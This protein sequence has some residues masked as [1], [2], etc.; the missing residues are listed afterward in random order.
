M[1]KLPLTICFRINFP[2]KKRGLQLTENTGLKE[3]SASRR[4]TDLTWQPWCCYRET[5]SCIIQLPPFIFLF[6]SPLSSFS[7]KG[8]NSTSPHHPPS[9]PRLPRSVG[10]TFHLSLV[11]LFHVTLLCTLS[12]RIALSFSFFFAF[13]A[14][15]C[16]HL[17]RG[18]EKQMN[19]ERRGKT[20]K[21][22]FLKLVNNL[23]NNQS[24]TLY[25]C[26]IQGQL[27]SYHENLTSKMPRN[28]HEKSKLL[29]IPHCWNFFHQMSHLTSDIFSQRCRKAEPRTQ[30][31]SSGIFLGLF[32]TLYWKCDEFSLC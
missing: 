8:P 32:A 23:I 20:Q 5:D 6:P 19:T 15:L 24:K 13:E 11:A 7:N 4:K 25:H 18:R 17:N 29:L 30:L 21:P 2:S 9:V 12:L 1:N 10:F 16:K 31:H 26:V 28:M 22:L 3:E 14:E 27:C